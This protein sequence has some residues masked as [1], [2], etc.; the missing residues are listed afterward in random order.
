MASSKS[1]ILTPPPPPSTM[2]AQQAWYPVQREDGWLIF[3]SVCSSG[4]IAAFWLLGLTEEN[5]TSVHLS[6]SGAWCHLKPRSSV[7]ASYAVTQSKQKRQRPQ[8]SSI[9][10]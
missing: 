2:T 9:W 1:F 8:Q 5:A 7:S 6:P 3:S 4:Y 10:A